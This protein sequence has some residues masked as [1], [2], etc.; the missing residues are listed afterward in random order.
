M[1]AIGSPRQ[2][3]NVLF[4]AATVFK[5]LAESLGL[6]LSGKASCVCSSLELSVKLARALIREGM[7]LK[8]FIALCAGSL[9]PACVTCCLVFGWQLR[10]C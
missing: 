1:L 3:F 4:K 7:L 9:L 5:S 10:P 6:K 2:I 8:P